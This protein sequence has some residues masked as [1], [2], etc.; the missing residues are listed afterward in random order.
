MSKF[1]Y[2]KQNFQQHR[3]PDS[4]WR[5]LKKAREKKKV[6]M[7][8][9]ANLVQIRN[10]FISRR[11]NKEVKKTK[12][13]R[14]LVVFLIIIICWLVTMVYL[15]YFKVSK[16][17]VGGC[18]LTK[19]DEIRQLVVEKYLTEKYSWWPR[20]N[21]F[22][23]NG[24]N[25]SADLVSSFPLEKVIVTKKFPDAIDIEVTEKISSIIYDNG[26][27]YFVLD[28]KGNL[29]KIMKQI[30][31]NEFSFSNLKAVSTTPGMNTSSTN[32]NSTTTAMV[33]K[34]HTPNYA[35]IKNE[36]G[37]Y[38]LLYDQRENRNQIKLEPEIASSILIWNELLGKQGI[39]VKY[40]VLDDNIS[41]LVVKIDQPF[42]V[43]AN[44]HGNPAS[45]IN[46]MRA[47]LSQYKPTEY[48][49]LRYGERVYWK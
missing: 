28:Q 49:D 34:F 21:Y 9:D 16:V 19:N 33:I 48:I 24:D 2:S 45:E 35:E 42:D 7:R 46:N 31:Q 39:G 20:S 23:I 25:I 17:T 27:K 30:N 37:N 40:F 8:I 10:P 3:T 13:K 29:V 36:V 38:P 43:M 47:I 32:K 11:E 44:I 26:D 41:G 15:P 1:F 4:W 12:T 5:R 6:L 22:F 18:K 14:R